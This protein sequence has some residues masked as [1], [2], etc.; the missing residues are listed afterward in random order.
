MEKDLR[1]PKSLL[2][3]LIVHNHIAQ[4]HSSLTAGLRYLRK[5]H[6]LEIPQEQLVNLVKSLTWQKCVHCRGIQR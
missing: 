6:L 1:I 3:R 4:M 5:F 2:E